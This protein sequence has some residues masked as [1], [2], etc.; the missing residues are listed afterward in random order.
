ML[1]LGGL[2][3]GS[4]DIPDMVLVE[5]VE[6]FFSRGT[7]SFSNILKGMKSLFALLK[8]L[9]NVIGERKT[10]DILVTAG[11]K[12]LFP[13][14]KSFYNSSVDEIWETARETDDEYSLTL[15]GGKY[16]L[17]L[18]LIFSYLSESKGIYF[19]SLSSNSKDDEEE[20]L[21]PLLFAA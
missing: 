13:D 10:F 21:S 3:Q 19:K 6:Q 5:N 11:R 8:Y 12:E 14:L 16:P 1:A 4:D 15:I 18:K 7:S 20:P 9:S 2:E 17:T